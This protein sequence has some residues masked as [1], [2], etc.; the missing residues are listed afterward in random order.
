MKFIFSEISQKNM[1]LAKYNLENPPTLFTMGK[2]DF[3]L[4]YASP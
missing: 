1:H 4:S 2:E 3:S